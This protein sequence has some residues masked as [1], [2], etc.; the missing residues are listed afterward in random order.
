MTRYEKP[1]IY[2]TP[3]D[4]DPLVVDRLGFHYRD[5]GLMLSALAAPMPVFG[6]DV[7]SGIWAKAA[8]LLTALARNHPLMD[9]NKRTAWVI[10]IAFLRLNGWNVVMDED[11]AVAFVVRVASD[12]AM[13]PYEIA[14]ALQAACPDWWAEDSVIDPESPAPGVQHS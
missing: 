5:R 14:D 9:G 11:D 10:T 4:V 13:E 12:G 8:A 2:I 6:V 3:D 7:H 1:V